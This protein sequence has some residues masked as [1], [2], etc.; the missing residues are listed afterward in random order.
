MMVLWDFAVHTD[1]KIDANRPD[2]IIQHFK[3]GAWTML[4]VTKLAVSNI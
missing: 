3:E 4:D 1:K 2:I